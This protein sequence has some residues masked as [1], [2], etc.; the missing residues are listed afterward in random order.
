MPLIVF[1]AAGL[2]QQHT[3]AD[4]L[5]DFHTAACERLLIPEGG[6]LVFIFQLLSAVEEV[7]AQGQIENSAPGA[8]QGVSMLLKGTS[9]RLSLFYNSS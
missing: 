3:R 8:G 6:T 4:T 5:P 1:M 7:A 2:K 9:P